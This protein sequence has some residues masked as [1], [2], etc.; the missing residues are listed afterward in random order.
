M[1]AGLEIRG[2]KRYFGDIRAVDGVDLTVRPGETVGFL[3]SNGAG[4]T[5]T[6]R[7]ILDIIAPQAGT[8]TWQGQQMSTEMRN[9]IGYMPQERGLY[10]RMKVLEQVIYF[11][12]LAGVDKATATEQSLSLIHI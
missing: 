8:I 6:M 4:K 2:L 7:M 10:A 3:G 5:T 12:R 11:A 1:A 9:A